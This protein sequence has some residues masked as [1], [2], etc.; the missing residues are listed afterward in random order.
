MVES[1]TTMAAAPPPVTMAESPTT[2]AA[3][4]ATTAATTAES[5]TTTAAAPPKTAAALPTTTAAPP[6]RTAAASPTATAAPPQTTDSLSPLPTTNESVE[7]DAS[8]NGLTTNPPATPS[9]NP[10]TPEEKN[11][12]QPQESLEKIE[13]SSDDNGSSDSSDELGGSK[14]NADTAMISGTIELENVRLMMTSDMTTSISNNETA[15]LR[16]VDLNRK[17]EIE[18]FE[19]VMVE[20][21]NDFYNTNGC[22]RRMRASHFSGMTFREFEAARQDFIS[23]SN[24]FQ[25]STK[26][27]VTTNVISFNMMIMFHDRRRLSG[28]YLPS[29]NVNVNDLSLE[30]IA[31]IPFE[32]EDAN[33][34]L[35]AN[36]RKYVDALHDIEAP[37]AAPKFPNQVHKGDDEIQ[38]NGGLSTMLWVVIMTGAVAALACK[39]LFCMVT[40]DRMRRKKDW[41]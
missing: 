4:P 10:V 3:P 25:K 30:E 21:Y 36:L 8:S 26:K 32:D 5:P 17:N 34:E 39:L 13:T 11:G 15:S 27:N 35:V 6:P 20:W 33:N 31:I 22:R 40:N 28:C 12:S 16:T 37:I 9:N 38:T 7:T 1:L 14:A 41:L 2:T 19:Q 29:R 18:V 23:D 24:G